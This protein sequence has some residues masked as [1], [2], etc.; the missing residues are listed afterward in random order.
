MEAWRNDKS[1]FVE[2]SLADSLFALQ[3]G[4]TLLTIKAKVDQK[5]QAYIRERDE[6]ATLLKAKLF[7]LRKAFGNE[8]S[9]L[10]FEE[11]MKS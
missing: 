3:Q 6:T 4:E 8:K 5:H 2:S 9:E 10:T 7:Q 11:L 1:E